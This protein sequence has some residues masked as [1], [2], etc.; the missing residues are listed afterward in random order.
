MPLFIGCPV[1]SFKGWVGN[2][3]P[4]TS[5]E[6]NTTFYAL[7]GSKTIASWIKDTPDLFRFCPKLPK[8]IS[9][10]GNLTE[11]IDKAHE[12]IG[13]MQELGSRLGPI[14]LQLPP[15]FSIKAFQELEVF[16]ESWPKKIRLAV[17]VRHRDWFGPSQHPKLVGMLQRLRME[18]VILDTCPIRELAPRLFPGSDVYDPLVYQPGSVGRVKGSIALEDRFTFLRF[19]GHPRR[20][21]N[22]PFLEGWVDR[23]TPRLAARE[24]VYVFCHSPDPRFAPFIGRLLYRMIAERVPLPVLPWDDLETGAYQQRELF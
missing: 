14:F 23:L 1:W 9:H 2:F 7:P 8:A 18:Q 5:I 11:N 13:R 22:S 12:F 6:A 19:A 15:A 20:Q 4:L 21:F 3:Y 24:D 16:L 17:E 10:L